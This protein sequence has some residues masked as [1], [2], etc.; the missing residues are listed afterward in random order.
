MCN[1]CRIDDLTMADFP[2]CFIRSLIELWA[3]LFQN[4]VSYDTFTKNDRV[5]YLLFAVILLSFLFALL[6]RNTDKQTN[7]TFGELG[8]GWNPHYFPG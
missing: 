1:F 4:N 6:T 8:C 5:Y 7:H 2:C 3:D